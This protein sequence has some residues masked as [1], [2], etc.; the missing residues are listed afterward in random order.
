MPASF[1]MSVCVCEYARH[2]V[3]SRC[4]LLSRAQESKSIHKVLVL[5][6]IVAR[7]ASNT[8]TFESK[9]FTISPSRLLHQ[10]NL[11]RFYL[12]KI[13]GLC[14]FLFFF[15]IFCIFCFDFVSLSSFFCRLSLVY[16]YGDLVG[17]SFKEKN[18][19]K[20]KNRREDIRV[21]G[22][23]CAALSRRVKKRR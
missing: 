18:T 2:R 20:E 14:M 15:F 1:V 3:K 19:R 11:R 12:R 23:Q 5:K 7:H 4:W 16:G 13:F 6:L 22:T 8:F 17:F 9:S 10:F 21:K